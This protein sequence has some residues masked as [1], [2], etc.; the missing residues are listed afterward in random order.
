MFI[1]NSINQNIKKIIHNNYKI[2]DSDHKIA[3]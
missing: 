3:Y 2:F 1:M